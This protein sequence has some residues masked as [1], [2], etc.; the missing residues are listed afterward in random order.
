MTLSIIIPVYRVENTLDRC[1]RSVVSQTYD[2]MEIILVDDGSPDRCPQM[3]DKWS[4]TDTR[5]T[6]IH[7]P[8]GGLSD[9]RNAGIEAARGEYITFIDS[10]DY[11]ANGT[12]ATV[13]AEINGE[14]D[15]L[16]YPIYRFY[17]SKRQSI[18]TFNS[19]TYTD[20]DDY[21]LTDKAY[22]HT[23]ACNK[24]FRR[25]LFADIRFP[26]GKLF[27]DMYTI[28][29]LL[30]Q[31]HT[32]ATTDKGMYYYCWNENG[33]TATANGDALKMLLNAHIGNG[34]IITDE[35]YYLHVMNIQ[36]DVCRMTGERPILNDLKIRVFK[37]LDIKTMIKAAMLNLLGLKR[38][39][40]LYEIL[41]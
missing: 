39:C 26:K 5:I 16:E 23:Y 40:K 38:L 25:T 30:K 33:I 1:V 4:E 22:N 6:T 11:I 10:D 41:H 28:P 27:E 34:Q 29:L 14:I 13:M 9:A 19:H 2:D 8:N 20:T 18:L 35:T 32:V 7:K 21:W 17:G 31:A 12:L 36:I 24:I 3:C 37:G 15:I